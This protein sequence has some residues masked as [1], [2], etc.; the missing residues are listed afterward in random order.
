MSLL[1]VNGSNFISGKDDL[2]QDAVMQQVFNVINS[3][4]SINEETRRR[5]LRI[6]TYKVISFPRC[7]SA[8]TSLLWLSIFIFVYNN[9]P[10]RV[11]FVL[12]SSVQVI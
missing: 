3:F 11:Y 7:L 5:R 10:L 2:R 12:L 8:F 1:I 4:L 6:R 9:L